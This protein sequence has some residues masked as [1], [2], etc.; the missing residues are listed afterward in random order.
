MIINQLHRAALSVPMN[1]KRFNWGLRTE[2]EPGLDLEKVLE[3]HRQLIAN[4]MDYELWSA[5]L[6]NCIGPYFKKLEKVSENSDLR[7]EFQ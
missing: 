1:S 4:P 3:V 5:K 6:P 2:P 7:G